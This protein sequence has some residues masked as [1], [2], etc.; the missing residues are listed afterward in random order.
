MSALLQFFVASALSITVFTSEWTG[1]SVLANFPPW[2]IVVIHGWLSAAFIAP[3]AILLRR[4]W[5]YFVEAFALGFVFIWIAFGEDFAKGEQ[6]NLYS[7]PAWIIAS[8]GVS[9]AAGFA[10]TGCHALRTEEERRQNSLRA[11]AEAWA[12]KQSAN[13]SGSTNEPALNPVDPLST[14]QPDEEI[15]RLADTIQYG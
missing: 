3:I 9:L 1:A 13:P 7:V 12:K 8:F 6:L 10:A 14:I 2:L 11:Q 5:G 15:T 4:P